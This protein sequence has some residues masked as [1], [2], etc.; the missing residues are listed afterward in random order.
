M[1]KKNQQL[2]SINTEKKTFSKVKSYK[3]FENN[4]ATETRN[5]IKLDDR[6]EM[7]KKK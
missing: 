7:Y 5:K 2:L 6:V 1:S 4:V 3:Y